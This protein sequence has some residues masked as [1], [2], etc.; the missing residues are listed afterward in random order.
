MASMYKKRIS[1]KP[2]HVMKKSQLFKKTLPYIY[3]YKWWLL[4]TLVLFIITALFSPFIPF[5]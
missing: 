3:K 2:K 4:L 1:N 5:I